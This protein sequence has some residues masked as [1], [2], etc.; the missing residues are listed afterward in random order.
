[1]KGDADFKARAQ[2]EQPFVRQVGEAICI[3]VV[4]TVGG[5]STW[6]SAGVI[7]PQLAKIYGIDEQEASILSLAV[8]FGFLVGVLLQLDS[9]LPIVLLN[10]LDV[11]WLFSR[12][13]I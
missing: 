2:I 7:I 5:M 9:T 11:Y 10:S 4:C 1:M 3:L 6:F 8:N 13:T 12:S